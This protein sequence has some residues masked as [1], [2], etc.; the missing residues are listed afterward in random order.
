MDDN[1][2]GEING[3]GLPAKK[4]TRRGNKGRPKPAEKNDSVNGSTG[5]INLIEA[6][7]KVAQSQEDLIATA[8]GPPAAKATTSAEP[9]G[10]SEPKAL[11]QQVTKQ[12]EALTMAPT[13]NVSPSWN[14]SEL[15]NST[16]QNDKHV[17]SS[18]DSVSHAI[19]PDLMAESLET[20]LKTQI[21]EFSASSKCKARESGAVENGPVEVQEAIDVTSAPKKKKNRRRKGKAVDSQPSEVAAQVKEVSEV[22]DGSSNV[23]AESMEV[24]E[25]AVDPGGPSSTRD[26]I[27]E[28]DQDRILSA[29]KTKRKKKPKAKQNTADVSTSANQTAQQPNPSA[30]VCN[31]ANTHD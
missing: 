15:G 31:L 24:S 26:G 9:S 23:P 12:L 28:A 13:W 10:S 27:S 22:P 11:L 6:I 5:D 4:K 3:V 30:K 19:K 8:I 21:D 1:V 7:R 14:M 25:Q 17:P 16:T 18:E 29:K 2:K 20:I